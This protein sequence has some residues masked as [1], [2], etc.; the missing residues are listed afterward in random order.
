M[1]R[2]KTAKTNAE[3]VARTLRETNGLVAL[4]A[5][6][7]GVSRKAILQY[8]DSNPE[9]REALE[10]ARELSLDVAEGKL[11]TAVNQGDPWAVQFTLK[12]LGRKRGFGDVVET[13]HSG[14]VEV[15]TKLDLSDLSDTALAELASVLQRGK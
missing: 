4:A 2:P 6:K 11:M 9:V 12:T 1:A 7:L 5:R 13:I 10:Q 15:T 3:E 14:K 8:V